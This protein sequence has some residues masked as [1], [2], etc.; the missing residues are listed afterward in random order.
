MIDIAQ[1]KGQKTPLEQAAKRQGIG[2]KYCEL[3]TPDLLAAGLAKSIRGRRGGYLPG[4]PA[5]QIT[6]GDIVRPNG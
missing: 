6:L 5:D 3:A 2:K 1:Q 4:K